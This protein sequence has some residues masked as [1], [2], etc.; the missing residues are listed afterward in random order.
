MSLVLPA[1]WSLWGPLWRAV[2]LGDALN[3]SAGQIDPAAD[4]DAFCNI[5]FDTLSNQG[6]VNLLSGAV[7]SFAT[8]VSDAGS[9]LI[10]IQAGGTVHFTGAVANNQTVLFQ[11]PGGVALI[12]QPTLTQFGAVL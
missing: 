1:R 5:S 8:V 2:R 7:V 12:D 10:D 9:G 4:L 11:P 6:T 3:F